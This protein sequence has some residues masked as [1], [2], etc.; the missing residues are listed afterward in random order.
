MSWRHFEEP[1]VPRSQRHGDVTLW[2]ELVHL[3]P[4]VAQT[5]GRK[6]L[7]CKRS[8]T[9]TEHITHFQYTFTQYSSSWYCCT[10]PRLSFCCCVSHTHCRRYFKRASPLTRLLVW[11]VAWH[12][13]LALVE[14]LWTAFLLVRRVVQVVL[15][16][17][18][19]CS[20]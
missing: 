6:R 3:Q 11:L 19:S 10:V 13:E 18:S 2:P 17:C 7:T 5:H 1:H 9:E 8:N 14:G 16:R 20:W 15:R 12:L 4:V